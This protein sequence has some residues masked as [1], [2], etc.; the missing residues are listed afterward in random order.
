[1]VLFLYVVSIALVIISNVVYHLTQK[2]TPGN[3]H[4]L[5]SLMV[6]YIAAAIFCIV[7]LPFFPIKETFIESI[8]K[9]NW[10]SYVLGLSI[11]GLEVGFLLVYRAG[12]NISTVVM[13]AN[14]V[15]ALILIPVGLLLFQENISL[16]N[17][18][19]IIFCL[20]GLIG[21]SYK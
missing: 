7:L 14:I 15:V 10:T 20:I 19:G 17:K 13:L 2:S 16:I 1:M 9:L 5:I 3:V 11:V 8:K 4:P 12:W 18:A 21:I 6:T